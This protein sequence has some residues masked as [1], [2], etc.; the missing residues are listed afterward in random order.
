VGVGSFSK[1]KAAALRDRS[2]ARLVPNRMSGHGFEA[3]LRA[4]AAPP[5]PVPELVGVL[6]HRASWE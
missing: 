5:A 1:K 4:L 2:R 6:R 3:F